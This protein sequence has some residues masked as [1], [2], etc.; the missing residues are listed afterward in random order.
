MNPFDRSTQN[1]DTLICPS[2]SDPESGISKPHETCCVRNFRS[3]RLFMMAV[4][5]KKPTPKNGKRYSNRS[6][7]PKPGGVA[8]TFERASPPPAEQDRISRTFQNSC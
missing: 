4:T 2:V 8:S 6:Q 1:N 7:R 3:R 5:H